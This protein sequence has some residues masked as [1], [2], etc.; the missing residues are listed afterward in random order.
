MS[1]RTLPDAGAAGAKTVGLS[2]PSG[3]KYSIVAVEV[4][5]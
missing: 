2:A 3:Q 4:K 5:P 1:K